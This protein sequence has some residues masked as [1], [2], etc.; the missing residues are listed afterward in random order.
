MADFFS[1]L[2]D[3]WVKFI[4]AQQVFFTATAPAEGRINLSPK[5]MDTFRCLDESTVGYLDLTGSGIET[6]SHLNENGRMT[7]MFCSFGEKPA[8][9]RLYGKGSVICPGDPDWGRY[10]DRFPD[11]PGKRSLVLMKIESAQ[12]S[13]GYSVPLMEFKSER[14]T[15]LKWADN[16]GADGI[17][18]Y[19]AE[20]NAVSI[21][22]VPSGFI[23]SRD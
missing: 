22:G 16:R 4:N 13:C 9:L 14:K 11:F 21:D 1:T 3:S 7:L 12:K 15:L 20:K 6:A 10:I 18:Q 8:I 5:G 2:D 23:K 17:K 19:W